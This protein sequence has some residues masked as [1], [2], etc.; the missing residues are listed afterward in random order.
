MVQQNKIVWLRRDLQIADNAALA[1]AIRTGGKVQ[2]VFVFDTDI[3]TRFENKKDRRISFIAN[4]IAKLHA[5][6]KESGGNLLVF[7]GSAKD[8]IPKLGYDVFAGEDYEPGAKVRD[9]YVGGKVNLTLVKEHLLKAPQ[10]VLKSDGTPFKVFTPYSKAWLTALK[11]EDTKV[12]EI[13]AGDVYFDIL[14]PQG[15]KLIQAYDP[16][17]ICQQI[18]YEYFADD[19]WKVGEAHK[20][21]ENFTAQRLGNYS[22]ARDFPAV[23]GTSQISPYL[24]FGLITIRQAYKAGYSDATWLKELIWREFY[25]MILYHFPDSAEMEFTLKYRSLKWRR[26]NTDFK[27]WQ[28]G[29]TRVQR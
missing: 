2:P 7:Y 21:L 10:E 28:E 3:L 14:V 18:G 15:L 27:K 25:A 16:E 24:R 29:K 17:K 1:R 23:H 13:N 6:F 11:D 5:E 20:V 4:A 19:I 12:Y 9:K 26:D 8:I 22:I